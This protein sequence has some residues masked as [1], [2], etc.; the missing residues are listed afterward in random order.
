MRWEA[1]SLIVILEYARVIREEKINGW[2][3][4]VIQYIEEL[5]PDQLKQPQI[6]TLQFSDLN[7]NYFGQ[8]V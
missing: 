2:D 1:H 3:N 4:L 5:W 7:Q 6:I 8:A